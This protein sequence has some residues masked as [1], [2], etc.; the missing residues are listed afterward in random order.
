M[1]GEILA[2]TADGD[3]HRVEPVVQRLLVEIR[4]RLNMDVV[5]VSEFRDG[6]RV[7]R[8]VEVPADAPVIAR[9]AYR[10]TGGVMV[11]QGRGWPSPTTG[12]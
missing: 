5:F 2:A 8:H 7:F 12:P 11:R 4:R 10:P 3:D 9:D 1:P 6:R